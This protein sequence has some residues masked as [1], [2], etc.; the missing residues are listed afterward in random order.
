MK[1]VNEFIDKAVVQTLRKRRK[2]GDVHNRIDRL[3]GI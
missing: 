2:G 1:G 3:K